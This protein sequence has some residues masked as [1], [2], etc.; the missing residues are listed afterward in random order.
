MNYCLKP[1]LQIESEEVAYAMKYKFYKLPDPHI[2]VC[3]IKDVIQLQQE[4]ILQPNALIQEGDTW[5]KSPYDDKYISIRDY[6][7][8][9]TKDK[10][11]YI[12]N[13]AQYLGATGVDIKVGWE[14]E[15]ERTI[16]V[17]G[18]INYKV[19][20][21]NGGYKKIDAV[22]IKNRYQVIMENLHG[23]FNVATY[24]RA[25]EYAKEHRINDDSDIQSLFV[26]RDICHG[27]VYGGDKKVTIEMSNDLNKNLEIAAKLQVM[28]NIFSLDTAFKEITKTRKIFKID[29][30]FKFP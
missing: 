8:V 23:P 3:S 21:V 5:I 1:I 9:V 12:A 22:D 14:N 10:M 18:N 26:A 2:Q 20:D 30:I 7:F 19:V 25:L 15:E 27:M 28:S 11:N 13:I 4:G 6:E 24:Q 17:N 16:D 29:F